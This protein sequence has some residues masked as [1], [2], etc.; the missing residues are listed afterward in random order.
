VSFYRSA[1]GRT[2]CIRRRSS[3]TFP[4]NLFHFPDSPKPFPKNQN[5]T[6][7]G[8]NQPPSQRGPRHSL[9]ADGGSQ[10][11]DQTGREDGY[12]LA[13][14]VWPNVTISI[15]S[16]RPRSPRWPTIST[17]AFCQSRI[18]TNP[19]QQVR[20]SVKSRSFRKDS[21][22]EGPGLRCAVARSGYPS[23]STGSLARSAVFATRDRHWLFASPMNVV[24]INRIG[25]PTMDGKCHNV[26]VA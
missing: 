26:G 17:F 18:P 20:S 22:S 12:L 9:A 23:P 7:S 2:I 3:L 21:R 5:C 6:F 11:N 10:S 1:L 4:A 25:S 14:T 16:M 19:L 13:E 8:D 15:P 24:P